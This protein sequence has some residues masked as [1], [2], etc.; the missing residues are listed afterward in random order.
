M[1][2]TWLLCDRICV[3]KA[4]LL[5]FTRAEHARLGPSV[6]LL[7]REQDQD[8]HIAAFSRYAAHLRHLHPDVS[9]WFDE[10]RAELE[11]FVDRRLD[12]GRFPAPVARHHLLWL[13]AVVLDEAA[14]AW[15]DA[16]ATDADAIQPT[17]LAL[18]RAHADSAR[19]HLHTSC[20]HIESLRLDEQ[21]RLEWTR[22][23]LADVGDALALFGRQD[24]IAFVDARFEGFADRLPATGVVVRDEDGVLGHGSSLPLKEIGRS[25]TGGKGHTNEP[26]GIHG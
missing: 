18:H 2:N 16:L 10:Q 13:L 11:R 5:A 24:P 8:A 12:P 9:G 20:A 4:R 21:E 1:C 14:I 17:W 3:L 22:S 7:Q 6:G 19:E 23:F 25:A 15:A 26:G